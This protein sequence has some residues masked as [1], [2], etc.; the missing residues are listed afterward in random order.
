MYWKRAL[1]FRL[2]SLR[3][4][5]KLILSLACLMGTIGSVTCFYLSQ[6]DTQLFFPGVTGE[7]LKALRTVF[8]RRTR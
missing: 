5:Q 6:G 2:L 7:S 8:T 3:W 1:P 4:G